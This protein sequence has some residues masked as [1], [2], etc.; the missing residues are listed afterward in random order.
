[1]VTA[2]LPTI[3][4]GGRGPA[5]PNHRGRLTR[6]TI[7]SDITGTQHSSSPSLSSELTI[8]PARLM[9]RTLSQPTAAAKRDEE[10][11]LRPAA[12]SSALKPVSASRLA[13]FVGFAT[14]CGALLALLA[15]L[16]LPA[17]FAALP[18]VT[19]AQAV[20]YSYYV[21]AV[22]ALL[23]AGA[24]FFGLRNLGEQRLSKDGTEGE[25]GHGETGTAAV[26]RG[27][28]YPAAE[29][30]NVDFMTRLGMP[31]VRYVQVLG[32]AASLGFKNRHIGLGYVGGFVARLVAFSFRCLYNSSIADSTT[33]TVLGRLLLG[34]RSSS[35]SSSMLTSSRPAFVMAARPRVA[36]R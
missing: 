17:R 3:A 23:A 15:F 29:E 25:G 34:F 16:P 26:R 19:A 22:V 8:T 33:D 6:P 36:K 9:A 24:S 2:I 27:L 32:D 13:G 31:V 18:G 7:A 5:Q 35:R 12:S 14:G 20:T 21:V 11:P 4:Y 30:G 1:M 10:P 28:L